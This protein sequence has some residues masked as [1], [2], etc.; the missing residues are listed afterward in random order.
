MQADA[1]YSDIY[2]RIDQLNKREKELRAEI[3]D[4]RLKRESLKSQCNVSYLKARPKWIEDLPR[5]FW[6][7]AY[8]A[9]NVINDLTPNLEYRNVPPDMTDW[10]KT[11]GIKEMLLNLGITFAIIYVGLQILF[12]LL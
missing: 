1:I 4:I 5:T 11:G 2:D 12:V 3:A 9:N 6:Y 7:P 8:A 10:Q